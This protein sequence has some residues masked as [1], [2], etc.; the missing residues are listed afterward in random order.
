MTIAAMQHEF[1]WKVSRSG[2]RLKGDKIVRTGNKFETYSPA[3]LL[4]PP[5]Y[6]FAN[7]SSQLLGADEKPPVVRRGKEPEIW[8]RRFSNAK[9][10]ALA[11]VS[12]YGF[13]TDCDA[14]SESVTDIWKS[15]Q[16][17]GA[18]LAFRKQSI[19]E[20]LDDFN[21]L[22]PP[23]FTLRMVQESGVVSPA[24]FPTSLLGWIWYRHGID[25]ADRVSWK[26]C[27]YCYRPMAVGAEGGGRAIGR[28]RADTEYCSD[29]CRIM[30]ARR[31]SKRKSK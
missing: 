8:Q 27:L 14:K 7:L 18:F 29:S 3:E 10:A 26:E 24:L 19:S 16:R 25:I 12:E 9:E 6:V 11:F 23:R 1:V 17:L 15:S 21:R 2:Y 22:I 30:Y 20:Q 5:S 4:P 13:L 28:Y 31:K